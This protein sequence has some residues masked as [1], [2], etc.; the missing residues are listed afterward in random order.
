MANGNK[1]SIFIN[2][3]GAL[4]FTY[5]S[6]HF[7][8]IVTPADEEEFVKQLELLIGFDGIQPVAVDFE[9][10]NKVKALMQNSTFAWDEVVRFH[11]I[12]IGEFFNLCTDTFGQDTLE[13]I[14]SDPEKTAGLLQ[15]HGLMMKYLYD[16]GKAAVKEMK[17]SRIYKIT[18]AVG[19][20][21]GELYTSD[22][23]ECNEYVY[24]WKELIQELE[25]I[26]ELEENGIL[27]SKANFRKY[28]SKGLLPKAKHKGH[29]YN[30]YSIE[31][32][33][34]L[35]IIEGMKGNM[36]LSEIEKIFK[37]VTQTDESNSSEPVL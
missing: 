18:E 30:T 6:E 35:R 1:V 7:K 23:D 8:R 22:I 37:K 10:K 20:Q 34:L 27:I 31:S 5:Y 19:Q 29:K 15:I 32:L 17:Q 12:G 14:L 21:A 26:Q 28:Q 2:E 36:K 16:T 4:C 33:F 11:N 3:S 13:A 9:T 25:V 24:T